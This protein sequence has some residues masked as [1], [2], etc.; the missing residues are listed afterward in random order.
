MS[1]ASVASPLPFCVPVIGFQ[2]TFFVC[3]M[4]VVWLINKGE[5][6]CRPPFTST[7]SLCTS[8]ESRLDRKLCAP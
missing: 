3:N 5:I 4:C 1:V 7:D 8:D 6:E 2:V